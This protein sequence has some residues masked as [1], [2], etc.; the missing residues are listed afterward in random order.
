MPG[1][2]SPPGRAE[3]NIAIYW[4]AACGGCDVSLLDTDEKILNIGDMSNIVMWPIAVDGKEKDIE[5]MEDGEITVAIINGAIRNSENEHMAK[6]LRKKSQIL[7]SYGACACLG[8][9]PALAN[10]VP[11][12]HKEIKDYVYVVS[13]IRELHR[14]RRRKA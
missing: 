13:D 9:S 3:I 12:G 11:G 5:A 6:L 14:R 8:G 2:G 4:A 1:L 10:L 7:V